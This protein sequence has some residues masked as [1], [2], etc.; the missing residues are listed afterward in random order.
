MSKAK[1]R[2]VPSQKLIGLQVIDNKGTLLGNVKDLG[3]NVEEKELNLMVA[4]KTKADIEISWKDI[5]SVEDVVLLA[6]EIE[7]PQPTP[8]PEVT[9]APPAP[10]VVTACPSCGT[11]APSHAKFCPKCGT[12]LR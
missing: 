6:R 10:T 9:P 4:T 1:G 7:L 5:Q 11:S 12:K 8:V 3:V 2:F